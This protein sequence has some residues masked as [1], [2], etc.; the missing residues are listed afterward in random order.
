MSFLENYTIKIR[1]DRLR[2]AR[3]EHGLREDALARKVCL[4]VKNLREIEES[5][6]CVSFYS[7]PVKVTA[8]K[9]VGRFLG[10]DES[11]FLEK[12]VENHEEH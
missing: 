3:F 5:E 4:S 7:Y 10:L 8:A 12:K 2:Q 11:E 6:S 9:R 1:G